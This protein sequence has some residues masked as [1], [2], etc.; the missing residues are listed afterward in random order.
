ML[1]DGYHCVVKMIRMSLLGC[2]C[3]NNGNEEQS[4]SVYSPDSEHKD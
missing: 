3:G 4:A 2:Y 1:P